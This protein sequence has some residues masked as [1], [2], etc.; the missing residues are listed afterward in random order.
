[1]KKTNIFSF[2]LVLFFA[3]SMVFA[4]SEVQS[5]AFTASSNTDGYTLD[6]NTG[7]RSFNIE[8]NFK[9]SFTTK[10]KVVLSVNNL[11]ADTK[12][13]IRYSVEAIS[14]SRDNFTVKIT[15]WGD[16][17]IYGISGFWLAHTEQ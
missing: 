7:N 8:V 4:Q 10:P 9:K 1:M 6:K 14:V 13:N 5:G 17:K 11:D 12:T 2:L 15:T 16:T 3:T